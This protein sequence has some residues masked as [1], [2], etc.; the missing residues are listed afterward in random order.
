ML[1][2]LPVVAVLGVW[3][4]LLFVADG[5]ATPRNIF[6]YLLIEAPERHWFNWLL[7]A[8]VLWSALAAAY[9]TPLATRRAGNIAL[10]GIG[11]SVA[12]AAWLT[13]SFEIALFASLPILYTAWRAID[14]RR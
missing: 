4:I 12:V 13:L 9:L 11:G 7:A 3:C 10:L 2:V 8:P 1:Y 14:A 6:E 5:P